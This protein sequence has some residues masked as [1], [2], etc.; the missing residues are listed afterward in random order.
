M[1]MIVLKEQMK[2]SLKEMEERTTKRLEE[3]NKSL[4][5]SQE[6]QEKANR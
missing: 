2:K 1:K 5:Q 4:K 3:I 6:K